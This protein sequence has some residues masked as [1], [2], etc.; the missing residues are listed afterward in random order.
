[1]MKKKVKKSNCFFAALSIMSRTGGRILWTKPHFFAPFGHF[2]VITK[3]RVID[4][5]DDYT[6]EEIKNF[7]WYNFLWYKGHVRRITRKNFDRWLKTTK[8]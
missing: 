1:M 6:E 4:F 5:V 8:R 7:K 3:N 2:M